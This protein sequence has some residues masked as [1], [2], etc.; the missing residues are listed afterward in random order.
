VKVD[1][2]VPSS[3]GSFL[4]QDLSSADVCEGVEYW[5]DCGPIAGTLVVRSIAPSFDTGT[6]AGGSLDA[7]LTL[8]AVLDGGPSIA[9]QVTLV[10]DVKPFTSCVP[11]SLTGGG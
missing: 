8:V 4:L 6:E 7:D 2:T 5:D 9:G 1:F 11:W 10:Y 3:P